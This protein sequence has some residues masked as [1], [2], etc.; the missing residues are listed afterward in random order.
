M[1]VRLV[2]NRRGWFRVKPEYVLPGLVWKWV[3]GPFSSASEAANG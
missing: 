1:R 2:Y 3:V